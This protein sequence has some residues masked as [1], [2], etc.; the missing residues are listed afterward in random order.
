M[1]AARAVRPTDLVA[2]VSFDGRVYPNEAH[3]WER[4]GAGA[5]S[6]NVL[7]NAM[8][9]WFSFAT[10]RH[11]W[12]SIQ[13]QTIRG[14]ISAR[15]RG[16]RSAWEID[17]LI[18]AAEDGDR[19][20]LSLFDQLSAGAAHDGV[21]K[22]FLRLEAGSELVEPARKAG[23]VPYT[24]ERLYRLTSSALLTEGRPA[25]LLLRSRERSDEYGLFQLYSRLAPPSV[26][27]IEA[28]TLS[29]WQA[30]AERRTA[31]RGAVDVVAERDGRL[32]AWIRTARVADTAR[33]DLV[34]DPTEW[35]ASDEL[36]AW[37]LR[38]I[39]D[40]RPVCASVPAYAEPI[41]ER[42]RTAGFEA[43][44]EYALL[45][46][47]LAAPVRARRPVPAAVKPVVTV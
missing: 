34:V 10:G 30:A 8:E 1:S 7:G 32:V 21:L 26:R 12:I 4:L 14:L 44:G 3:P 15:R 45:A 22:V 38:D 24:S 43:D 13:R 20:A 41:G 9:Q 19:V 31:G 16:N 2:L 40:R 27:M 37:A 11:T 18:A 29:E 25:G 47:R 28:M 39:G 36:L 35:P 46:K 5:T 17:C 33:L 42:L 6:P 23:F